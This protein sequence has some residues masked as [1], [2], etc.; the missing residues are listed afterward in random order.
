VA[1]PTVPRFEAPRATTGKRIVRIEFEGNALYSTESLKVLMR[2]KE[3]GTLDY[4]R[5]DTDMDTLF[6]F[7]EQ[8]KVVEEEVAG[9]VVLKIYVSENPLV[10][11]LRVYG[12]SEIDEATIRGMLRTK[13]GYP[14]YP[15][16]LASDA[17]DIVRA[18]RDKGFHFANVPEPAVT[19]LPG[20]GRRVDFYVVEGPKVEVDDIVFR[21]NVHLPR[22][23]LLKA[24]RTEEEGL[25]PF[26]SE[27][28]FRE[29][30]LR[31]D[32]VALRERYRSEGFL[33]AEIILDDLRFSDDKEYAR[34]SI[35]VIEHLCYTVGTVTVEI[36][37]LEP[38]EIGAP[39]PEDLAWFTEERIAQWLG[40][41]PGWRYSGEVEAKGIE[42]IREQ[43][44]CRSYLDAQVPK[45]PHRRAELR[46]RERENVVDVVLTVREGQ[47]IRLRRLDFVGHE[48]TRD[49]VLR[50]ETR[51]CPGGYV[52]RNELDRTTER[53]RRLGYFD[54]VEL[55]LVESMGPDGQPVEGWKDAT[56]G[57]VEGS[58]GKV[59]FGVS[60][61]TDGGFG[62]SITFTKRNFDIGRPPR[63]FS[64]MFTRR[65][66]T[67][68]GQT[69]TILLA[70]NTRVTQFGIG[71]TEPHLFDTNLALSLGL[72]KRFEF[73]EDYTIDRFGYSVGLSH[74]IVRRD[75]DT[76]HATA[77]VTWRHEDVGLGDVDDDAVPGAFLFEGDHEV[78]SLGGEVSVRATDDLL[79]PRWAFRTTL[80]AE[81]AGGLLGGDIDMVKLTGS[82]EHSFLVFEDS[83]GRRHRLTVAGRVGWSRAL[84]DTPEVP[85]FERFY[86]GGRTLRGFAWRGV[87]PHV[88]GNPTGG[89]WFAS[90][91]VE[92]EYPI[93]KDLLGAV[94]FLDSGVIAQ[95]I[96]DA[97]ADDARLSIGFGIRLKLPFF[98]NAP[99]AFD[100]GFPLIWYDEDERSLLSFS[101]GRDF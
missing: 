61:S 56:Y 91:S 32:L 88:N 26:L 49:K 58:T 5:L 87:G 45:P 73:Y 48:Y 25:V 70:P 95:R 50:R 40:L 20:G 4:V 41:A 39:P 1:A 85:P 60:V 63:S 21:G 67:G 38:G 30:V 86:L 9:G 98:G 55:N 59:A 99:L 53:L 84:E 93:V 90:G 43:Y 54:R 22:K 64:E 75:D 77:G 92:Y 36:D 18:Y 71:F 65:A 29:D 14:L 19:T 74:P 101:A 62:G 80:R 31:E 96:E 57:V 72:Q 79:K 47:K 100:F 69:L 16:T 27:A 37:R 97:D 23:E 7:F 15:Y 13:V 42:R 82:H 2:L 66:F 51:T 81:T 34:I 89:E 94:A 44:F 76:L 68:G 8:V 33:D 78:R 3:G 24:M 35:L 52:D 46:A 17:Q 6:R 10:V 83:E 12:A 11:E 28:L